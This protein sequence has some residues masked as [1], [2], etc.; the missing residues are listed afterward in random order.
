MKNQLQVA[1]YGKDSGGA[2]DR[3]A[4]A[5]KQR[6]EKLAGF[7]DVTTTTEA[8]RDNKILEIQHKDGQRVAFVSANLGQ[9]LALGD[10]TDR[11]VAIANQVKPCLHFSRSGR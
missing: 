7:S 6:V 5:V 9:G 4:Q 2:L 8:N 10:A 11:V 1:L 3:T